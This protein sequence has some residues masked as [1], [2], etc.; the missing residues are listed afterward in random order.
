MKNLAYYVVIDGRIHCIYSAINR[1]GA[2]ASVLGDYKCTIGAGRSVIVYEAPELDEEI[3][4]ILES[5]C[6][7]RVDLQKV[8][9]G[10]TDEA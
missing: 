5:C 8:I 7:W 9:K 4:D 1:P 10:G 6:I 2:L 3:L